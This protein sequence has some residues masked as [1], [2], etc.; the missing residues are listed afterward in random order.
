MVQSFPNKKTILTCFSPIS[1]S[2]KYMTRDGEPPKELQE[3]VFRQPVNLKPYAQL[4]RSSVTNWLCSFDYYAVIS[5]YG[6]S[7]NDWETRMRDWEA[8]ARNDWKSRVSNLAYVYVQY[9]HLYSLVPTWKLTTPLAHPSKI[10]LR[11]PIRPFRFLS[12]RK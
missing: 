5:N 1:N 3:C 9:S 6:Q 7:P 4:T 8:R 11:V 10:L 2:D 12:P